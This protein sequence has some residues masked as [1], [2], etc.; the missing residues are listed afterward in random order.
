M[1]GRYPWAVGAGGKGALNVGATSVAGAAGVAE[2]DS[3]AMSSWETAWEM[4]EGWE[5]GVGTERRGVLGPAT[6][7]TAGDASGAES[8][9]MALGV[10]AE[11]AAG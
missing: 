9:V 5:M 7:T 10:A 1:S 4:L 2:E 6:G 3:E 8:C 11:L